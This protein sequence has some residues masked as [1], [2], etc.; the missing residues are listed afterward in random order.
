MLVDELVN[1]RRVLNQPAGHLDDGESLV[2]AVIRETLEETGWSFDP[3]AL[4]GIYRWRHTR[5][6]AT[7][8]RIA[9]CGD[10]TSHDPGLPLDHGIISSVWMTR[11]QLAATPQRLRSPMVLRC[12]NDYLAGARHSLSI[13]SD[14]L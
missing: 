14:I 9:F 7:F 10:V 11:E 2:E 13:L 4:V 3:A 5:E 1:G 8:L 12:I 6:G